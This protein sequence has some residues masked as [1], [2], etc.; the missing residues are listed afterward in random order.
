MVE[1][2]EQTVQKV[3]SLR[4]QI[5]FHNQRYYQLDDPLITDAEYDRLMMELVELEHR[6]PALQTLDSPTQRVGAKA[7]KAFEPVV[8]KTAMLSLENAFSDDEIRAFDKRARE[9]LDVDEIEY[10][11]E[12]KLDGLAISLVYQ[13]GILIRAATRGDGH[14]GENVTNNIRTIHTI[15]LHLKGRDWPEVVEVRGEVFMPIKG[16]Q[17]LN[18]RARS[19]DE[20]VFANPRNAAAGS[21]RQLDSKITATRP[22]SFFG[23]GHGIISETHHPKFH[24]ELLEWF[25]SWGIPVCPGIEV[26]RCVDECITHYQSLL[27][28]RESLEYQIDGVV[29]KINRFDYRH[30]MGF[31]ARA[32]R[33][34]IA[35][36]FPA[37]EVLTEVLDID[38]QVG[39]T[40]ALTPVAR[41][42]PIVVSGVTVTNATLHNCEEIQR[43]DVRIGDTVVVRRAGDVIPEVARVVFEKRPE[44]AG[45]FQMPTVCPVCGS[46]VIS[47]PGETIIR[48]SGGL[49]CPA[50]HKESTKHFASRQALDIEGLGDKLVTQLIEKGLIKTVADLYLLTVDQLA[51]LERMGQKSAENLIKALKQSKYTTFSRFLYALGIRDVGE[52]TA[53]T[54]AQ[55]FGALKK[56][57][58]ADQE[59]LQSVPDVGPI[60]ARNIVLFFRQS[61]NLEVIEKLLAAGITWKEDKASVQLLPLKDVTAVITGTLDS[62]TREQ[63]KSRL[64][65]LGAKVTSSVSSKTRYLI[66]GAQPG[67]KLDKAKALGVEVLDEQQLLSIL[68]T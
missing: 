43:K 60:V 46:D 15:P 34:A 6:F 63:A 49:F 35:R 25:I 61:H 13:N 41:L 31:V 59:Q 53:Q 17:T 37:E 51:D 26:V 9:R 40:G 11:A 32:P 20:K 10:I 28:R 23:Y 52:V 66:A 5:N 44:K 50:Q 65:A 48:C 33:W 19:R 22:L 30:K 1:I 21:L 64:Q 39:R 36:K 8:H 4:E 14:T 55:H 56:L 2:P 7:L 3:D 62:M 16:F 57:Q 42:K 27:K 12:P 67:S 54:L 58:A 38:V 68:N 29:F 47:V 45:I 18:E 24:Q